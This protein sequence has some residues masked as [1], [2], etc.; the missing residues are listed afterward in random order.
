MKAHSTPRRFSSGR[1]AQEKTPT[2]INRSGNAEETR[3]E[4]PRESCGAAQMGTRPSG[5]ARGSAGPTRP[6]DTVWTRLHKPPPPPIGPSGPRWP[7]RAVTSA[8]AHKAWPPTHVS[9]TKWMVRC[10]A[11]VC[12]DTL[13]QGKLCDSD[14]GGQ[15]SVPEDGHAPTLGTASRFRCPRRGHEAA[16]GN[17]VARQ[18][19][20]PC[21][22]DPGL[23]RRAL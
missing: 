7:R 1:G 15:N 6:A 11:R 23:P 10:G 18:P 8:R 20:L 14:C 16:G 13:H 12:W 5:R 21:G 2:F 3:S 17:M 4:R 22:D 9:M 19:A